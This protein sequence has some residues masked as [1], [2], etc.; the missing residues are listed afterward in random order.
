MNRFGD[1]L[2]HTHVNEGLVDGL[3]RAGVKL[4]V[5]GGLA[6]AWHCAD[7]QADDMDLLIEP[8][9]DNS[10]RTFEALTGLGLSG[11]RP[12]SFARPGLQV[13][14]KGLYYAELLTPDV[15]GASFQEVESTAVSGN[16]FGRPVRIASIA[17]LIAM[18]KRAVAAAQSSREKHEADIARLVVASRSEESR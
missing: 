14:I 17:S 7:R 18:K 1:N 5:V 15:D 8:T 13:P 12:E 9:P 11:F 10:R 16:L 6:V 2:I 3:L 4:V